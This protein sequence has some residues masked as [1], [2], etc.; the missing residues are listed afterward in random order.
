MYHALLNIPGTT[1]DC[2]HCHARLRMRGSPLGGLLLVASFCLCF[3]LA[4]FLYAPPVVILL[5]G[6]VLPPVTGISLWLH[7]VKVHVVEPESSF[8]PHTRELRF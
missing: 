7:T 3:P 4:S 6:F 1:H 2:P 8:T 5:Y